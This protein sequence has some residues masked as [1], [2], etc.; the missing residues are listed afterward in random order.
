VLKMTHVIIRLDRPIKLSVPVWLK[1]LI[2]L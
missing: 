1:K 2:R